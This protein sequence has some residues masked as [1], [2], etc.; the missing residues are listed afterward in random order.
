MK[1]ILTQAALIGVGIAAYVYAPTAWDAIK[2]LPWGRIA[3]IGLFAA[4][5]ACAWV[6]ATA[7]LIGICQVGGAIIRIADKYAPETKETK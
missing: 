1:R 3:T 4:G 6:A 2:D 7:A 5:G